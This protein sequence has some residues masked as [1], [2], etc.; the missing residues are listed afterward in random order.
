MRI[1]LLFQPLCTI[2][3]YSFVT[4]FCVW[5]NSFVENWLQRHINCETSKINDNLTN[6]LFHLILGEIVN[7]PKMST[8]AFCLRYIQVDIFGKLTFWRLTISSSMVSSILPFILSERMLAAASACYAAHH[9]HC[10]SP[11]EAWLTPSWSWPLPPTSSLCWTSCRSCSPGTNVIK[12]LTALFTNV[13]NKLKC[14]SLASLSSLVYCLL[15]KQEPT[16]LKHF[17]GTPL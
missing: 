10:R 3:K 12:L 15:V 7:L 16:L 6:V 8:G 14:L 5:N 9:F 13:R 1:F 11:K 17:S 4:N 2:Q